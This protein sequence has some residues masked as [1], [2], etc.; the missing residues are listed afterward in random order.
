ML[1]RRVYGARTIALVFIGMTFFSLSKPVDKKWM[2]V[3][4]LGMAVAVVTHPFTSY[5]GALLLLLLMATAWHSRRE[6][7]AV[8]PNLTGVFTY[9]TIIVLFSWSFVIGVAYLPSI[10]DFL[11]AIAQS[12]LA[13]EATT[14]GVATSQST[15]TKPFWVFALTAAGLAT[16]FFTALGIFVQTQAAQ[17]HS[18]RSV[19][20]ASG[21]FDLWF[22]CPPLPGWSLVVY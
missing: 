19:A 12:L 22:T 15:G 3:A 7:S 14:S 16:Y 20:G 2:F 1:H 17:E 21:F 13:P 8:L 4:L 11:R 9:V 18:K 10:L 5:V 6:I